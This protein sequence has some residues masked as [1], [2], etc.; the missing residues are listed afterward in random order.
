VNDIPRAMKAIVVNE[1]GSSSQMKCKELPIPEPGQ[2]EVNYL[3]FNIIELTCAC[4]PSCTFL[5]IAWQ[6]PC[7]FFV[8]F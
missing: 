5:S 6:Y 3:Q 8:A 4:K 1:I 7:I 2:N